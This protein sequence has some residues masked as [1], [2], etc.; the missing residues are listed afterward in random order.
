MPS[1]SCW[2]QNTDQHLARK[3]RFFRVM[4]NRRHQAGKCIP[5]Y[6]KDKQTSQPTMHQGLRTHTLLLYRITVEMYCINNSCRNQG[7]SSIHAC[8]SIK[9]QN[10]ICNHVTCINLNILSRSSGWWLTYPSEKYES[11]WPC[12]LG[13]KKK[14]WNYQSVM[15]SLVILGWLSLIP[16]GTPSKAPAICGSSLTPQEQAISST[17]Y[18]IYIYI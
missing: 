14:V 1:D 18:D 8:Q 4:T 10:Y 6:V 9:N 2:I 15:V 11:Q 17:M 3:T 13:R 5:S 7:A 16:A 12:I